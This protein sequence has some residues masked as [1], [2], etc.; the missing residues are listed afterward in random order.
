[1]TLNNQCSA[2]VWMIFTASYVPSRLGKV[3][4][5]N[6]SLKKWCGHNKDKKP[7]MSPIYYSQ[8][9][10]SAVWVKQT[11]IYDMLLTS[12]IQPS[13]PTQQGR[14]FTGNPTHFLDRS[15]SQTGEFP[16]L[17]EIHL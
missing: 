5:I 1:M 2:P 9:E 4:S 15:A 7:V 16:K 13:H 12:Y 14:A 8:S 6:K 3:E 11:L 17:N 10:Q